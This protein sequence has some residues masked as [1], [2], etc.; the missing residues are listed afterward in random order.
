M[1][2]LF[3]EPGETVY[4]TTLEIIH[5]LLEIGFWP[6]QLLDE[7]RN[8]SKEDSQQESSHMSHLVLEREKSG[9]G[10]EQNE[11]QMKQCKREGCKPWKLKKEMRRDTGTS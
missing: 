9:K 8:N 3:V 2:E 11:S 5:Y 1:D 4:L 6:H 7:P 10:T